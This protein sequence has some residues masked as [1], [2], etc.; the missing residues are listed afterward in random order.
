[1]YYQAVETIKITYAQPLQ[2][3]AAR[4]ATAMVKVLLKLDTMRSFPMLFHE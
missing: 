2:K 1:M 4:N 3:A